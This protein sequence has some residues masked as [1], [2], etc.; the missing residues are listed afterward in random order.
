MLK[1]KGRKQ[2]ITIIALFV[3]LSILTS[4]LINTRSSAA[5]Q[6]PFNGLRLVYEVNLP[7][8][9]INPLKSFQGTM[10]CLFNNVSTTSSKLDID[11]QGTLTTGQSSQPITLNQTTNLPTNT[12][13]VF[14]LLPKTDPNSQKSLTIASFTIEI[15]QQ[16][17]SLAGN[18]SYESE[19]PIATSLGTF[20]TYRF[21][22]KTTQ[23][24]ITIDTY[25]HYEKNLKA[26]IYGELNAQSSMFSYKYTIKLKEANFQ[27]AGGAGLPTSQCVIATAAF[28]SELSPEVQYLRSFRDNIVLSTISGS[29]FMKAFNAWYYSFS[30]SVADYLHEH[31]AERE[32]VRLFLY[33]LINILEITV[34]TY[35][36]FNM[37]KE[38]GIIFAGIVASSLI[39][40]VYFAPSMTFILFF[41]RNRISRIV[42]LKFLKYLFVAQTGSL[43]L[44]CLALVFEMSLLLIISTSALVLST[45]INA[46][47]I[48]LVILPYLSDRKLSK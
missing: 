35:N 34:V 17:L 47:S 26:M 31:R 46:S 16:Q 2:L 18:F 38:I 22:N 1:R 32:T 15:G 13:T 21:H 7:I 41:V 9:S 6:L 30:P 45:M 28:G 44:V 8:L 43:C 33:P 11:I 3:V 29:Q 20:T 12:D 14:F 48:P 27:F 10:V 40:L 19:M 4:S 36:F 39:G 42:G 23:A 5:L 24:G 37:N 25:L